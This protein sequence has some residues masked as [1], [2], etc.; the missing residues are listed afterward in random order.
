MTILPIYRKIT[1]DTQY[2]LEMH[3]I[4]VG[5]SVLRVSLAYIHNGT[6]QAK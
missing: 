6:I 2:P 5:P 1:K 3:E 4:S